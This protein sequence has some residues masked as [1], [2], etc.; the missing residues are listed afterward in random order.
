MNSLDSDVVSGSERYGL[1][2]LGPLRLYAV[3]EWVC[4]FS[5]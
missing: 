2:Q 4:V 3:L 1:V 5:L